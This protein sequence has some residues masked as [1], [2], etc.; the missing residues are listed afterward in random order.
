MRVADAAQLRLALAVLLA[1][2]RRARR[3]A[4]ALR[5]S[6]PATRDVRVG[7][8]CRC[9]G[10]CSASLV[11]PVVVRARPGATCGR[12]SATSAT[13]PTSSSG[14][15]RDALRRRSAHRRR[16]RAV[17]TLVR[18][19]R[20]GL[21]LS[22]TTSDFYVA[23]RTVS[24]RAER[25]GDRRRVPL[26]RV[27]PRRRRAGPRLR[28]RHAV[29]PGRLH[30]RATSCCSS[31][32]PPRCAAPA[33]TRC[34]TS[35]RPGSESRAVRRLCVA[36]SSSASA[37]STCCRSS[38]APGSPCSTV[39]GAPP[40][41]GGARRRGGRRSS[42]SPPAG[43]ARSP[44]CRPF[45]YWLKLT[46]LAVPAFVLLGAV[47]RRRRGRRRTSPGATPTWVA[48]R[49]A[50]FGG[51][52]HPLYATYSHRARALLRHHGAAARARPLLHQPRR[53]GR[54][55]HHPR[56]PRPARRLL[57][58]PADLRRARPGLRCPTCSPAGAPTPSCCVL[59]A[60]MRPRPARR[61]AVGAGRRRR[62]RG[63]PVDRLRAD[64]LGRRR[65]RPGPAAGRLGRS[66]AGTS[67]AVQGFRLAAVLAVVVP[68][69]LSLAQRRRRPRR[70][71]R[72]GLRGGGVDVLPAAGARDLVA[73]AHR[74]RRHGRAGRRRRRSPTAAVAA[75]HVRRRAAAG[76]LGA[77]LGQPAAW[78]VPIAFAVMV[79]RLAAR[80]RR[81]CP[82]A[83]PAPWSACTPPRTSPSDRRRS[84]ATARRTVGRTAGHAARR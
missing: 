53:P 27:V 80:R 31:S 58:V 68:Y 49:S 74:R 45:Q 50:G 46:A 14:G 32:S 5:C 48:A 79:A 7:S 62:V 75:D 78:T 54:P 51:R 3:A 28:R 12:P 38:R 61:A 82:A 52:D 25:L 21:R 72:A 59:P 9:R 4:A 71:G 6:S 44:S 34:P 47:A 65:A 13:S 20:F 56:R 41:V 30:R 22:R 23:S 26:G 64:H 24:A 70:H 55:A 1:S 84:P 42:T 17:A 33:P 10:C 66:P 43:C 40:W 16:G 8:G 63:V 19:A 39:T 83:P 67:A 76:W 73:R 77:L 69:L 81:R 11:Y 36:C 35:P 29:V 15:E 57:P 18:S 2:A 37:G 60:A